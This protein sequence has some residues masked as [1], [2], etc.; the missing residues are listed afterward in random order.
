MGLTRSQHMARIAGSDTGP[1]RKLRSHLWAK[2]LRYRL[3]RP[4]SVGRPDLVFPGSQVAVF[5]DGCFWHGCPIHYTPPRTSRRFWASKLMQNVER[6]R[7]QTLALEREGW[8]VIRVW[9]HEV[10]EELRSVGNSIEA[11]VRVGQVPRRTHW[12]VWKVDDLFDRRDYQRRYLTDL[13]NPERWAV[14]EGPR[15][16]RTGPRDV[17]RVQRRWEGADLEALRNQTRSS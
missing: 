1:E 17:D 3:H 11:A 6:D 13:R 9:E 5:V 7:R 2:G 16:S 15:F 10:A 12:C 14:D 4:T 8:I